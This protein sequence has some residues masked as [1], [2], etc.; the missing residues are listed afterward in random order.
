VQGSGGGFASV[1]S[2]SRRSDN[3]F[4]SA[5]AADGSWKELARACIEQ[6]SPISKEANL[7]FLYVTDAASGNLSDLL[8]YL[9]EQTG[10]ES[11]T[12]SVGLGIC[13]PHKAIFE[14]PA[15]ALMIAAIPPQ[16][17]Q[18]FRLA[19]ETTCQ[20]APETIAWITGQ[21]PVHGVVHCDPRRVDLNETIAAT[22][23]VSSSYLVGAA[24]SARQKPW[25]I[26]NTVLEG[27]LSG[28]L[29]TPD[30][31]A[32]IGITQGCSAIGPARRITK[33][34]GNVV[35]E[36]DGRP[37]LDAFISDIGELQSRDLHRAARQMFVGFPLVDGDENDYIVRYIFDIDVD[38]KS[39]ATSQSFAENSTI[40]FCRRDAQSATADLARML[41]SMKLRIGQKPRGG[42]YFNCIAR[43]PNMFGPDFEEL[44]LVQDILGEFPLV[45]FCGNG[46]VSHNRLYYYTGV[47]MVFT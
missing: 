46:E 13:T 3:R 41:K 24:S 9:R 20:F 15:I 26:A 14:R 27:G 39:F 2:A 36:I 5:F 35:L 21:K 31:P 16:S 43:G 45:G 29:L 12:G 38:R 34:V 25:Q 33:A 37:A 32:T 6:L 28:V 8:H 22:S 30:V 1:N 7:G 4:W 44:E 18:I 40:L 17:F 47:L 42:L 19:S 11:W 10:I 23:A